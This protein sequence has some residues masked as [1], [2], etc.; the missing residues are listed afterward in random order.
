MVY[1]GNK[2]RI[3]L[4][5]DL[6]VIALAAPKAFGVQVGAVGIHGLKESDYAVLRG[7]RVGL[8]TNQTGVDS[9]GNCT[10]VL[11]RKNCNLVVS[12]TPEHGLDGREPAGKY[13]KSRRSNVTS[14]GSECAPYLLY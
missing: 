10:R 7:K 1:R 3:A 9:N 14:F 5:V 12:Y 11:L 2:R 13:V 8:I 6:L 4:T